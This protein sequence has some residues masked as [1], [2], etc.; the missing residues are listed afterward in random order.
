MECVQG[1]R[2]NAS[3]EA[4]H[5][6]HPNQHH[7]PPVLVHDSQLGIHLHVLYLLPGQMKQLLGSPV[8]QVNHVVRMM[9]LLGSPTI[10]G[11]GEAEQLWGVL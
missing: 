10:Q 2:P 6:N 5:P 3:L 8:I 4:C 1:P 7:P 9:Q 11:L